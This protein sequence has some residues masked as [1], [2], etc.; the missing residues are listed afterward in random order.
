MQTG[1]FETR[2]YYADKLAESST[3]DDLILYAES[4]DTITKTA[5][6]FIMYMKDMI[7]YAE[8]DRLTGNVHEESRQ[9]SKINVQFGTIEEGVKV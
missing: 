5:L 6:Y 2:A 8:F 9:D 4:G 1:R 7:D 3:K